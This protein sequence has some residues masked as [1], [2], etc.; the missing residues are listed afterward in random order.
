MNGNMIF[1]LKG[2][3]A[4][5]TKAKIDIAITPG[6]DFN[7]I[8]IDHIARVGD[9]FEVAYTVTSKEMEEIL[10]APQRITCSINTE[11]ADK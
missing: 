2:G 6:M 4:D 9:H 5:Y 7:G 3:N 11:Y 1:P 8:R 10:L